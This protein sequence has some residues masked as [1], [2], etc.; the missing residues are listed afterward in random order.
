MLRYVST[1]LAPN[2]SNSY[3]QANQATSIVRNHI[4]AAAIAAVHRAMEGRSPA[5]RQ[6]LASKVDKNGK[7][8][9]FLYDHYEVTDIPNQH[10]EGGYNVVS[11]LFV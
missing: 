5:A 6:H 8:L 4:K 10:A 11:C 7:E 3:L 9:P 2:C 1:G